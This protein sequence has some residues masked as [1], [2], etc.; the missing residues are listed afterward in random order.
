MRPLLIL[1]VL[2]TLAGCD[3]LN[4]AGEPGT[5]RT[6]ADAYTAEMG[7]RYVSFEVPITY[8]NTTGRTAYFTGCSRPSPPSVEKL[9]EG[10]WVLA[11][12]QVYL[13]CLAP[14]VP[15]E[16]GATFEYAL[17]ATA[18]FP[19]QNAAPEWEV[20]D[21]PG[22]YRLRWSVEER[23]EE[24]VIYSNKFDLTTAEG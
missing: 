7:P 8:T 21:V 5:L 17:H 24:R 6:S 9:V 11:Y 16:A 13:M 10:E 2:F 19:G 3:T 18:A 14:P 12:N 15:V 20:G 22:T 1:S 23:G 4:E